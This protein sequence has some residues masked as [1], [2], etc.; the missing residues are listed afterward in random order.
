MP[1]LAD[2]DGDGDL[3]IMTGNNANAWAYY[4]NTTPVDTSVKTLT[5][6]SAG[7]QHQIVS[8]GSQTAGLRVIAKSPGNSLVASRPVTYTIV[9]QPAGASAIL[10]ASVD[11]TT[12]SGTASCTLTTGSKNGVYVV[13]AAVDTGME[14]FVIYTN[15]VDIAANTW[16]L[17]AFSGMDTSGTKTTTSELDD[18][19]G[20]QEKTGLGSLTSGKYRFYTW[21]PAASS[22]TFLQYRIDSTS[23]L[24][25]RGYWIKSFSAASVDV[26]GTSTAETFSVKLSP[27]WNLIAN[28]FWHYIGY[29]SD[30][31]FETFPGN[32]LTPSSAYSSGI[33]SENALFWY[34]NTSGSHKW[35]PNSTTGGAGSVSKLE[36]KPWLGFWTKV[37]TGCTMWFYPN[38]RVPSA[39]L[40]V[41]TNQAPAYAPPLAVAGANGDWVLQLVGSSGSYVD[42][43]NYIGVKPKS[44]TVGSPPGQLGGISV[45]VRRYLDTATYSMRILAGG[46]IG[47]RRSAAISEWDREALWEITATAPEEGGEV[48]LTVNNVDGV[49]AEVPLRLRD[50]T[51]GL[52]QNLRT[53]MSYTYTA[54]GGEARTFYLSASSEGFPASSSVKYPA[55][56]LLARTFPGWSPH[57]RM[58]RDTLMKTRLG[59]NLISLYYGDHTALF[60]IG[61]RGKRDG[62]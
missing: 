47:G 17:R 1:D 33:L 36:V 29:D 50:R 57:L 27:G 13:T 32:R 42:D 25:G 12:S 11:T 39:S 24:V 54:T 34:D 6:V 31:R 9:N 23:V 51:T 2:L 4:Q 7:V 44:S 40:A 20:T 62:G 16:E 48:T 3:D 18:N 28:P 8:T 59:R 38:P 41:T 19:L 49:P 60:Q 30:I 61:R 22:G 10:S 52:E 26:S 45:S 15:K 56:C 58:A 5:A 55:A 21:D 14:T 37:S 53:A 43:L 35:G 46:D